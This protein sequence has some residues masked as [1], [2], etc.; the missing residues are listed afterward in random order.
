MTEPHKRVA[1]EPF[2]RLA[3]PVPY[4]PDMKRPI[5]IVAG[6]VIV[7]VGIVVDALWTTEVLLRWDQLTTGR[8]S[9]LSDVA[10]TADVVAA[11]R[12]TFLVVSAIVLVIEL[13]LAILVFFGRNWARVVIMTFSALFITT[14]FVG[15]W[16]DGQE[17]W[18]RTSI[19]SLAFDI[20][21]LLALSSRSAAAHARRH[22][23]R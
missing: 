17:I 22:E 20:L 16:A 4:N 14:T 23:R 19:L 12:V 2:E 8:D 10:M 3:S 18:L 7:L 15:W 21:V 6:V 1:F 5:S 11:G 13:V 9:L